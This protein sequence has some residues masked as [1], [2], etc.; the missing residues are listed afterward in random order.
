MVHMR[1]SG[2]AYIVIVG[3]ETEKC[4]DIILETE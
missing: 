4:G 2:L 1:N 3:T